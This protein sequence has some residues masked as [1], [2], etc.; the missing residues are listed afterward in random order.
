MNTT[1]MPDQSTVRELLRHVGMD[2]PEDRI[3]Q[4]T[5][6]TVNTAFRIDQG[7]DGRVG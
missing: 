6:G 3:H 7:S 4:V 2:V 1:M 5:G